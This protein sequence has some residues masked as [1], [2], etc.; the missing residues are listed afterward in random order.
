MHPAMC[1]FG[2]CEHGPAGLMHIFHQNVISFDLSV[3]VCL[4]AR[5]AN[6]TNDARGPPPFDSRQIFLYPVD[7]GTV[8][9]IK[10]QSY[11]W[12]SPTCARSLSRRW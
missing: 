6:T 5:C 8:V 9:G 7:N 11:S 10:S 12:G 3:I 1:F 4:S 2:L